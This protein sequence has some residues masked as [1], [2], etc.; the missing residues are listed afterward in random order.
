MKLTIISIEYLI[1]FALFGLFW[2]SKQTTGVGMLTDGFC[3]GNQPILAQTNLIH[4]STLLLFQL[5]ST[6][7]IAMYIII[8]LFLYY[9]NQDGKLG[10]PKKEMS[11][12]RKKNAITLMGEA[13]S[14][15][16]AMIF[17][18]LLNVF[19]DMELD[20]ALLKPEATPINVIYANAVN[21]LCQLVSS[22]E[23]MRY[24]FKMNV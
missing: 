21:A 2:Y 18:I 10:L 15:L 7:Q 8:F 6:H 14:F 1:G 16:I 12:R 11:K 13:L 17:Y 23:M 20:L 24:W 4:K 5:I 3:H 9:Q 19:Q 22:P